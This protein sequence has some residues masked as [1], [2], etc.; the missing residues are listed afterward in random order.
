MLEPQ[1]LVLE[2]NPDRARALEAVLGAVDYPPKLLDQWPEAE[3]ENGVPWHAI[4]VGDVGDGPGGLEPGG[5]ATS[6]ATGAAGDAR[7]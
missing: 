6:G 1:I 5:L 2:R 7:G 4:V 3:A